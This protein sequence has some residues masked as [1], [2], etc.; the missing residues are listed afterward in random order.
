MLCTISIDID[1]ADIDR[2]IDMYIDI[3]V[4]SLTIS[5]KVVDTMVINP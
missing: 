3:S 2:H 4:S 5:K 1:V